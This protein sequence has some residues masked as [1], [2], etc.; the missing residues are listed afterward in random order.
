MDDLVDCYLDD[1]AGKLAGRGSGDFSVGVVGECAGVFAE[2]LVAAL[3]LAV[4]LALVGAVDAPVRAQSD[5]RLAIG[6]SL[7]MADRAMP[8]AEGSSVA[9]SELQRENGLV[10]LFWC[11]TCPW[12]DRWEDRVLEIARS[13]QSRGVGFAAINPN[14][15]VAYPDDDLSRMAER[16]AQADYPFP[17]LRD[18]GSRVARTFGASRTPEVFVFGP[19]GTLVYGGAVD[20]SPR[21]ASGVEQPYL[22]QVLDALVQGESVP[23]R[24]T[25]AFGCTIKW[26]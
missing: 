25:K 11:N 16:A 4:T 24:T 21:G 5:E 15:P 3:A 2:R 7:P 8:S 23:V 9:L 26:Q 19:D 18:E 6:A 1:F 20:D 22:R 12:V 13:Y 10:V 14:D 17:Y